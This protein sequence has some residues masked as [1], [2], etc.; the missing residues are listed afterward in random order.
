MVDG[1]IPSTPDS[2][3][4]L[5]SSSGIVIS[6]E[7][8]QGVRLYVKSARFLMRHADGQSVCMNCMLGKFSGI[9]DASQL[10]Q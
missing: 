3:S 6:P 4:I 1:H 8:V 5:C 2:F 7:D 10:D 9:V